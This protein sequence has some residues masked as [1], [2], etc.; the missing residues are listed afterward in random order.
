ME[1]SFR[2]RVRETQALDDKFFLAD[3][4]RFTELDLLVSKDFD[5]TDCDSD[6][7]ASLVDLEVL[8]LSEQKLVLPSGAMAAG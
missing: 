3:L 4:G 2:S 8:G 6:C 7:K 1:A 5:C